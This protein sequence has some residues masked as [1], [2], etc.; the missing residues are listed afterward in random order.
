[1]N[2][3]STTLYQLRA[4]MADVDSDEIDRLRDVIAHTWDPTRCDILVTTD[5]VGIIAT[6]QEE[7]E[8][9]A[10]RELLEEDVA[11]LGDVVDAGYKV[12]ANAKAACPH[13]GAAKVSITYNTVYNAPA[14]VWVDTDDKVVIESAVAG[15]E[16]IHQR[17]DDYAVCDICER[18]FPIDKVVV[19]P[20]VPAAEKVKT[21]G[22]FRQLG[23][24]LPREIMNDY[25]DR[26]TVLA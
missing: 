2:T 3:T 7:V 10:A 9:D 18:E 14:E 16:Y 1:M 24:V 11:G 20:N 26:D 17:E 25:E 12:L 22:R 5:F 21:D 4:D 23:V 13:C 19:A 8:R 15:K 6:F